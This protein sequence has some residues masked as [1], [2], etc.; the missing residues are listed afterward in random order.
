MI[1]TVYLVFA[2]AAAA[3]AVPMSYFCQMI[4]NGFVGWNS[5]FLSS[6]TVFVSHSEH[7]P[8]PPCCC[9]VE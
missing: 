1:L 3:A 8:Q 4:E 9:L 2:T 6:T 7:C 5:K